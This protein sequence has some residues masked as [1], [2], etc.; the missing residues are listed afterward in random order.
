MAHALI[1]GMTGSGKSRLAKAFAA[2]YRR[3]GRLVAVLDPMHDDGWQAGYKTAD[4]GQFF[5]TCWRHKGVMCFIDE[6]GAFG[7]FNADIEKL[8]TQGRHLG[9]G[10][11]IITQRPQQLSPLV[12][13]QCAKA[14]VFA[15]GD[16]GRLC[17]AEDFGV[18]ELA[19]RPAPA[20]RPGH[21]GH[22]Y[23]VSRFAPIENFSI[24]F[25]T[26]KVYR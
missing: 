13:E 24:D 3:A 6:G 25:R 14:Y 5:A 11:T 22:F 17:L 1:C 2:E 15:L 18:P 12:R 19:T 21:Y 9:H 8:M 26:W 23:K 10:I 4:V 20:V 16:K 7:K